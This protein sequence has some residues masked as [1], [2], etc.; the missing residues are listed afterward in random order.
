MFIVSAYP[1]KCQTCTCE[2]NFEWVKKTFEENDAGFQY[3]IDKKGQ[4]AYNLHNQQVLDKI[5]NAKTSE[6]C[7]ELL[8]EWLHFFRMCHIGVFAKKT[9]FSQNEKENPVCELWEGDISKFEEYINSKEDVDCEG[10]W[11]TRGT[12]IGIKQEGANYIGFII[13]SEVESWKKQG[14]VLFRLEQADKKYKTIFYTHNHSRGD[15]GTPRDYGA[16]EFVGNNHIIIGSY[17]LL[18]RVSPGYDEDPLLKDY[19]KKTTRRELYFEELSPNTLYL[20]IPSFDHYERK[21]INKIIAS[22][23]RKILKTK[24]LMIDL[25]DNDGGRDISF[26]KLLPLI[27]TNPVHTASAEFL[28]TPLNVQMLLDLAASKESNFWDRQLAKKMA[29]KMRHRLGEF[30][31]FYN[32]SIYTYR[33]KKSLSIS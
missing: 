23:K 26:Q 29:K 7:M 8:D 4:A 10:I 24:N 31:N 9:S 16:P 22:N 14:L 20:R 12:K 30:I 17:M 1:A 13:E 32:D 21:A 2:T 18:T 3:I 25:R 19:L 6:E 11:K 33:R 27:Y 28:S 5:R 15:Y